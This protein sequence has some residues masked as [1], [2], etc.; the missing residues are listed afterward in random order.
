MSRK[1]GDGADSRRWQ[2]ILRDG[3]APATGCLPSER[4]DLPQDSPPAADSR[5]RRSCS[6][7]THPVEPELVQ[8]CGPLPAAHDP[9]LADSRH[10]ERQDVRC[11]HARRGQLLL[12]ISVDE[13]AGRER[14]AAAGRPGDRSR[15]M[16]GRVRGGSRARRA[17]QGQ[18][19]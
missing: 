12:E 15:W 16:G 6:Q 19:I 13:T 4:N 5:S 2:G 17:A 14:G 11:L 1:D 3:P 7:V 9:V 18:K 8:R 10:L